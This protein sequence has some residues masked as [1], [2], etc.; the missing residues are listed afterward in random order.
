[1]TRKILLAD[2][3]VTIQKVVELTFSDGAY[4]VQCVSNGRSAVQKI[5]E[6]QPD[7]LLCD[8]I[9]PEMNGYDVATFVKK[10]PSYS[11]I[12]VI[13]LT[14]TF[15]PFDEDKARQSGADSYITKPF[16]SKMLVDKVEEL[17]KK[18]VAFDASANEPVQ[19]FHSRTEFMIGGAAAEELP[20]LEALRSPEAAP[21]A[22]SGLLESPQEFEAP[23]EEHAFVQTPEVVEDA[24]K[25][26]RMQSI[27]LQ[28]AFPEPEPVIEALSAPVASGP[29]VVDL[30][31]ALDEPIPETAFAGIVEPELPAAPQ[32]QDEVVLSPEG[33]EEWPVEAGDVAPV[34]AAPQSVSGAEDWGEGQAIAPPAEAALDVPEEIETAPPPAPLPPFVATADEPQIVHELTD[35][36][37]MVATAHEAFAEQVPEPAVEETPA[38]APP[39]PI[40]G[41]Y[42]MPLGEEPPHE[43]F[44]AATDEMP[45]E[46]EGGLEQ[47]LPQVPAMAPPPA[48]ESTG[49]F[50]T[51]TEQALDAV[52]VVPA[53]VVPEVPLAPPAP[54]ISREELEGHVRRA[55]EEMLPAIVAAAVPAALAAHVQDALPDLARQHAAEAVPGVVGPLVA[56]AVPD[57]VQQALPGVVRDALPGHLQQV[58]QAVAPGII[59]ESVRGMAAAEI[60]R[61]V[62]EMAPDLV[63]QVAW[64]VIPE[65]AE[66]IIKRRIQELESEPG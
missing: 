22:G 38:A 66:S 30:G 6:D 53:P 29:A 11:S 4:Q 12:P 34:Q 42:E 59:S 17:L 44:G 33:Q 32:V 45:F 7:I 2:D 18:R 47:P 31:P 1:M 56:R 27:D 35:Q 19:V 15:E 46:P 10:N 39:E 13:L 5:Q 41:A 16:D 63:R 62:K 20:P 26:V 51:H 36:Q 50:P 48:T 21:A 37:S 14:G 65:L 9:M 40:T 3:S 64:E 57:A 55:A 23:S 25:T 43:I 49:S 54:A 28:S 52:S 60:E 24:D 61:L 58:A 8:V